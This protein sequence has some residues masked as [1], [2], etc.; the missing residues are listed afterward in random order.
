MQLLL[1]FLIISCNWT[2][3]HLFLLKLFYY[4]FIQRILVT[5][6]CDCLS[7][8]ITWLWL[9]DYVFAKQ[10]VFIIQLQANQQQP[11]RVPVE[12]CQQ[13]L[14]SRMFNCCTRRHLLW[15][16]HGKLHQSEEYVC[17]RE[18]KRISDQFRFMGNC[19]PTTLLSQHYHLLLT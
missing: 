13:S 16:C 5:K 10:R 6:S 2:L 11:Q 7:S 17:P 12:W 19:P 14:V 18:A 3:L 4:L 1:S 9:W 8:R 15:R